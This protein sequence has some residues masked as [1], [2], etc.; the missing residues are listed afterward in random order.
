MEIS[1]HQ[2]LMT[3][4]NVSLNLYYLFSRQINLSQMCSTTAEGKKPVS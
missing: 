1:M 3:N 4:K 2:Q